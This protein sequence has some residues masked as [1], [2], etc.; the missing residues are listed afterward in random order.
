MGQTRGLALLGFVMLLA[1]CEP[2]TA[3][4]TTVDPVLPPPDP[5]A[6]TSTTTTALPEVRTGTYEGWLPDGTLYLV[7]IDQL[8]NGAVEGI[9]AGIV[10]DVDGHPNAIGIADFLLGRIRRSDVL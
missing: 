9:S 1:A 5:I 10:M 6:S 3:P 4:T 8:L 7:H 2:T